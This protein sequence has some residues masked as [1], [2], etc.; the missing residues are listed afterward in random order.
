MK[1]YY[2]LI[3]ICSMLM[4]CS[5]KGGNKAGTENV[6]GN[7]EKTGQAETSQSKSKTGKRI[8][9]TAF[10][11]SNICSM[12]GIDIEYR[13]GEHCTIELEGDSALLTHVTADVESGQ[14]TLGLHSDSNK[15][16]NLYESNYNITAYITTPTLQ[17]VSL[18]GSGNFRSTGT[19]KGTN[20]HIGSL[21]TGSFDVEEVECETF[22][23]EGTFHD[24][25]TFHSVKAN[26]ATIITYR[27]SES[28]FILDVD[29][30]VIVS[31]GGSKVTVS[32]TARNKQIMERGNSKVDD[33]L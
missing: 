32:G 22:K 4:A 18:C 3:L 14:L 27:K 15:D 13:Q 25:S 7:T 19:I 10:D 2:F 12:C 23:F 1:K 9:P 29:D 30:L 6:K 11:F 5:N 17:Y 26:S 24:R 21:S 16:I 8:I 20:I 33:K 28:S 31:E